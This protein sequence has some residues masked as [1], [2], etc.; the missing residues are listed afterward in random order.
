MLSLDVYIL[1]T[2]L[3]GGNNSLLL[4]HWP[5]IVE[6]IKYTV[7]LLFLLHMFITREHPIFQHSHITCMYNFRMNIFS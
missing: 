1:E 7:L 3:Q 6:D 4:E 5:G 2:V